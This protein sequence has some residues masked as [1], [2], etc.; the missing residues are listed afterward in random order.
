MIEGKVTPTKPTEQLA[1]GLR[2][3]LFVVS[4]LRTKVSEQPLRVCI[5]VTRDSSIKEAT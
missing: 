2:V 1:C 4:P 3:E 5:G